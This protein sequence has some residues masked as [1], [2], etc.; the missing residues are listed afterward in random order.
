MDNLELQLPAVSTA[1]PAGLYNLSMLQEMDDDEYLLDVLGIL[2]K[3]TANDF[4]EMKNALQAGKIDVVCKQAHKIKGSAGIIQAEGL[5][6]LLAAIEVVGKKEIINSELT[7]LVDN[8][9]RQY[10]NIEKALKIDIAAL[11]T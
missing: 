10:S 6:T 4:G 1:A 11:R 5:I 2:V 9:T 3:Q 7:G 8:A